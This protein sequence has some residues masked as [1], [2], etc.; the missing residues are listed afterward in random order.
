MKRKFFMGLFGLIIVV[1]TISI[2]YICHNKVD[3]DSLLYANL[4]ALTDDEMP[5]GYKRC[6]PGLPDYQDGIPLLYCGT[7]KLKKIWVT[8]EGYCKLDE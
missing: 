2:G 8:G 6:S 5:P 1:A 3:N 4:E 7:C